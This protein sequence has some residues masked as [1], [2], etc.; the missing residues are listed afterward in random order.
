M[1][2][3]RRVLYF[4]ILSMVILVSKV[5]RVDLRLLRVALP[6]VRVALAS[7]VGESGLHVLDSFLGPK[8]LFGGSSTHR[9]DL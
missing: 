8:V 5:H 4:E 9:F 3:V 6:F 7:D 1:Q 2:R